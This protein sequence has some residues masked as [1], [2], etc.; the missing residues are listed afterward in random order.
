MRANSQGGP[1]MG[2]LMS[3]KHLPKD[4]GLG[5]GGH[6]HP[7]KRQVLLKLCGHG[8]K[9]TSGLEKICWH[10]PTGKRDTQRATHF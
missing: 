8:F 5:G 4:Q 1:E 9:T 7:T 2:V 6:G 3:Q 10:H